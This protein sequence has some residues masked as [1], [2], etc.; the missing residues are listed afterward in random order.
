MNIEFLRVSLLRAAHPLCPAHS[1][2]LL[3]FIVYG[4]TPL[5]PAHSP[6]PLTLYHI[7][8]LCLWVQCWWVRSCGQETLQH[9]CVCVGVCVCVCVCGGG[10]GVEYIAIQWGP[11]YWISI[12][13][14]SQRHLNYRRQGGTA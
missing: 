11:V 4:S 6:R 8:F 13:T 2:I 12:P 14:T 3:I 7:H 9:L 10:G 1:F 5:C